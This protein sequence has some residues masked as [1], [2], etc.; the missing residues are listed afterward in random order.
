[1][2]EQYYRLN[3]V[4]GV[5]I[6]LKP[7]G[8]LVIDAC[9]IVIKKNEL[10]FEQKLTNV[11]SLAALAK[12]LPAKIPVSLNLTGAGIITKQL[13]Q[14]EEITESNFSLVLPNAR[15]EDY[16]IQQIHS[17]TQLFVSLIRKEKADQWLEQFKANE[18]NLL[19]LSLD[20]LP[21][22]H[23]AAQLN[24]YDHDFEINGHHIK[25]NE[26]QEWIAYKK[27]PITPLT[28]ALKV[29]NEP[30]P[31][32][33]VLPYAAAF[34]LAMNDR[35]QAAAV[36]SSPLDQ[37]LAVTIE[38]RKVKAQ[39]T[40]VLLCFFV[41]LLVNFFVF[42]A[43]NS[44]NIQLSG[45]IGALAQATTGRDT[46]E[47]RIAEMEAEIRG[48]GIEQPLVRKSVLIDQLASLLPESIK[49]TDMAVNP[50]D[51]AA[52]RINKTIVFSNHL[53]KISGTS[54]QIIPVNEWMA[55]IK[56]HAWVKEVQMLN[57]SYNHEKNTGVFTIA[58][59]F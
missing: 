6:L 45:K 15:W 12:K 56:T 31:Q 7:D 16:Y 57:Y 59:S 4:V 48:L 52:G 9:Q 10:S 34:Q 11:A 44:A 32:E 3:E 40:V 47:K 18:L 14:A 42:N 13:E 54:A 19:M 5:S 2:L 46:L 30:L 38:N 35:L 8:S 26:K 43:K 21:I 17:G 22:L 37:P 39:G 1:M 23:I 29:G 55:R 51:D 49:L 33:L 28:F 24:L 58:I 27:Q 53:I 36:Q 50:T 25:R 20:G 41:L